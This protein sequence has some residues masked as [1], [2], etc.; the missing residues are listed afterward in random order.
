M[1]VVV[2]ILASL[3][4]LVLLGLA[5]FLVSLSTTIMMFLGFPLVLI[6]IGLFFIVT[7]FTRESVFSFFFGLLWIGMAVFWLYEVGV[8]KKGKTTQNQVKEDLASLLDKLTRPD[9]RERREAASRLGQMGDLLAIPP[10]LNALRDEDEFVRVYA[11]RALGNL[12]IGAPETIAQLRETRDTV[13]EDIRFHFDEA[14]AKIMAR[15]QREP[16][17]RA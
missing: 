9:V 7:A 14:I 8:M 6:C 13:G 3:G 10:L 15:G 16:L 12:D 4:I 17:A 5:P 2:F 1:D 11:A